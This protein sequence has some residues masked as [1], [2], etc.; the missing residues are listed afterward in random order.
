MSRLW[1]VTSEVQLVW[2]SLFFN[3]FLHSTKSYLKTSSPGAL[4]FWPDLI[5]FSQVALEW[6]KT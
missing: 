2:F 4:L 5:L 6:P 3:P 1:A